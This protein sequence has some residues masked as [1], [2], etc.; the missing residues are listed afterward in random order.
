ML[1]KILYGIAALLLVLSFYQLYD[2]YRFTQERNRYVYETGARTMN[3]LKMEVDT[4][5]SEIMSETEQLAE[6]FEDNQFTKEEIEGLI[7]ESALNIPEI[8]GITACFEP[9][10]QSDDQRL[11]CP[12]YNKGM[13]DFVQVGEGYDYTDES[14]EG[15][16]W[17]TGV[18]NESAQ[19][20]KPYFAQNVKQWFIDY[21]V[22]FYYSE[23]P[24]KGKPKGMVVLSLESKRFNNLILSMSLGKTGYGLLVSERG[25]ILSHPINSY[26]GTMSLA[27]L[28]LKERSEP[29]R[30]AFGDLMDG[31]SGNVVFEREESTGESIFFYDK[32]PAS[33]WGI[34]VVLNKKE[35]LRDTSGL[36][37]RFIK[38]S[39]FFSGLLL[40]IIA[41]YFNKDYLSRQE[42]W[43]LSALTTALLILNIGFIWYLQ[44]TG[45]TD[46]DSA[47]VPVADMS[48]LDYYVDGRK[49]R[50]DA[51][52]LP[53]PIIVPTGIAV[54]RVTFADSYNLN[55][56]G[57]LWQ[58][59]PLTQGETLE[60]GFRLPQISPFA[61]AAY[62][63]ETHRA[64]IPG[65]D[66]RE[67][68]MLIEW[69]FRVTLQH[70]FDYRNFPF[71]RRQIGIDILPINLEDGLLFV[72]DLLSYE[73]TA[74][75]RKPGLEPDLEIPGN[76]IIGT[77]FDFEN[78]S[79][80]VDF[81]IESTSMFQDITV[82]RYN[83]DLKRLM[84]NVFVTYLIPIFVVLLM[85]FIL[86]VAGSKTEQR[87]GIITAM[88]AFFFVL[89]F[90]HI[91]LR[92][93][94]VTADLMFM[95]YFYF[96]TYMMIVVSTWNLI[97]YA[98]RGT[99][100]FDYNENQIFKAAYFPF[101]FACVLVVTLI[102]FY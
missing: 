72:P 12:F 33:D 25:N 53:P 82:L 62:V 101:F 76:R 15:A 95:E 11:Y 70:Y 67:G 64:R 68:Y 28:A 45:S 66:N 14:V 3:T 31:N 54:A 88:A 49:A 13:A 16:A 17:Y 41:I 73:F 40:I 32:V 58:K 1:K 38:L 87:H 37:R 51:L 92:K 84:V 44:Y 83:I 52:K 60:Y 36:Q 21:A 90:S 46:K 48:G 94:I 29:L 56:S 96:I 65:N 18:I 39:I 99:R 50:S 30:Q 63:E 43:Q 102:K 86:V 75:S 26:I 8:Q 80:D 24:N 91:D 71:D 22:P 59:Y 89:I 4:L 79:Y 69:E 35:L 100:I 61:E 6:L 97:T 23:G 10:A 5:L 9:Y 57:T 20:V 19:W 74:P 85:M 81:G 42:I 7:K 55:V 2:L 98:R 34:A 27:D 77:Y 93:E 47:I 78:R